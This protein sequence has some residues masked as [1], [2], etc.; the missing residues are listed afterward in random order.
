MTQ[1]IRIQVETWD[2]CSTIWYETSRLKNPTD[3]ISKRVNQQL[4][5]LN[6]RRIEVSLSPATV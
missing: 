6:L 2:G 1:T 4:C 5:G 3:V